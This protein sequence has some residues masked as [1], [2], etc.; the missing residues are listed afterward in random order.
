MTE[1]TNRTI[2]IKKLL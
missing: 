1:A 2:I